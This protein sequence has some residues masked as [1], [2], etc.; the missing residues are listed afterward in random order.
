MYSEIRKC[1]YKVRY[2]YNYFENVYDELFLIEQIIKVSIIEMY[3]GKFFLKK[4]FKII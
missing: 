2:G 1:I 3:I 4:K